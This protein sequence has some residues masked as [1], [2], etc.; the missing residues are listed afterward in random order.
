MAEAIF[1]YEGQTIKIQCNKNQKMEEICRLLSVKIN[2][3]INSLLFLSEGIKLNLEKSFKEITKENKISILVYKTEIEIC[4]KCG[5]IIN[6]EA[7]DDII[8]LNTNTDYSL[9]GVKRQIE[10]VI[11]DIVNKKDTNFI[12]IQLNNINI[13]I[14]NISENIRKINNELNQIKINDNNIIKQ[15]NIDKKDIINN[16]NTLKHKN[17]IN[18]KKINNKQPTIANQIS[19]APRIK[20]AQGGK[21]VDGGKKPAYPSAPVDKSQFTKEELNDPDCIDCLNTL[22]VLKF[23]KDK[24]EEIRSKIDGRTPRELM[25][26]I[27]KIK[28]KYT[29]IENL[30]GD[31]ITPKDYLTLLKITFEHD[32]KL[33]EYFK[34]IGDMEK[35]ILVGERLP[36]LAK[37]TEELKNYLKTIK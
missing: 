3:D 19:Q 7:I 8:S 21:P 10:Q 31:D 23:K 4:P 12:K 30:M 14:N 34:Q 29:N 17:N 2:S 16:N 33:A 32:K 18:N 24:Y 13:I 6:N 37:E 28:C 26:R 9:I 5:R 11:K 20:P 27:I 36:L 15:N 35:F 25:L 1:I 22:S